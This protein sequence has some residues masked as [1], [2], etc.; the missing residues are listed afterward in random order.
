MSTSLVFLLME[1]LTTGAYLESVKRPSRGLCEQ[2]TRSSVALCRLPWCYDPGRALRAEVCLEAA[3]QPHAHIQ[4][5][6]LYCVWGFL[7]SVSCAG[8]GLT[9]TC[10]NAFWTCNTQR[11]R[12]GYFL[13]AFVNQRHGDR[14]PL[15]CSYRRYSAVCFGS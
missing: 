2:H 3:Q 11:S 15:S 4:T 13:R 6:A 1:C 8:I 7:V 10:C 14:R 9:V 5:Q 12:V